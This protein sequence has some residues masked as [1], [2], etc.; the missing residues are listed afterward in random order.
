M[1][2]RTRDQV[3]A[4]SVLFLLAQAAVAAQLDPNG[5]ATARG[6]AS[7][8]KLQGANI[9]PLNVGVTANIGGVSIPLSLPLFGGIG[10]AATESPKKFYRVN[11]DNPRPTFVVW[12]GESQCSCCCQG[13]NHNLD[14]RDQTAWILSGPGQTNTGLSGVIDLQQH[15]MTK[16]SRLHC[17]MPLPNSSTSLARMYGTSCLDV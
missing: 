7:S 1:T 3:L 5:P 14:A 9:F 4:L 6:H 11:C 10:A 13:P 15:C 12:P 16:T 8:R 2:Q 17:C